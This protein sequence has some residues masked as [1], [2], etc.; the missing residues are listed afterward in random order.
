MIKI[1]KSLIIIIEKL[2]KI[3]GL[4]FTN[5]IGILFSTILGVG[6]GCYAI[7]GSAIFKYSTCCRI[8]IISVWL[9]YLLFFI[10]YLYIRQ[11][12]IKDLKEYLK[13][14]ESGILKLLWY[15]VTFI[16]IFMNLIY[17]WII[18][19]L[20]E[21]NS[22]VF[23]LNIFFFSCGLLAIIFWIYL[24]KIIR[25][26]NL[27]NLEKLFASFYMS[28]LRNYVFYEKKTP[29]YLYFFLGTLLSVLYIFFN[30]LINI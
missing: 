23:Y 19:S 4:I 9:A 6:V 24:K 21:F 29:I 22:K 5:I 16:L 3:W 13:P 30:L 11:K 14:H 12:K 2:F 8:L 27:F 1:F 28:S 25:K 15:S 10:S 18:T 17:N 7:M 26:H 20:N